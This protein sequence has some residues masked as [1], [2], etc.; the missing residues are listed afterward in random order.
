MD[1]KFNRKFGLNTKNSNTSDPSPNNCCD[2]CFDGR[3][4]ATG[5]SGPPGR[6]GDTGIRGL[7]GATGV[8]GSTGQAGAPGNT[9]SSGVQGPAGPPGETGATGVQGPAGA[10][11]S[12]GEPGA[13]GVQGVTGPSGV[14]GETG[15]EGQTGATGAA[16][17]T[18]ATG[19][20]VTGATGVQGDTGSPGPAGETGA[21]GVG[22]TG[23][24]GASGSQG[25]TGVVGATGAGETGATGVQGET[26]VPGLIGETGATGAGVTGATG[27]DGPTG[28]IGESGATGPTGAGVTGATGVQGSTGATGD[29]GATGPT[30]AGVTGATGVEGPTGS[31]GATGPTGAGVTGA[32][33][34][35]GSTGATGD[36]GATGPTGAG[37]TG[38][39]GI[40]GLTGV[41]GATGP[42]GAGVTGATGPEGPTGATG[43]LG[44]TGASGATGLGVTGAT[45]SSGVQGSTGVAGATGVQGAT[46]VGATGATGTQGATGTAGTFFVNDTAFV[47]P[48]Y[49]NDATA[50]LEDPSHPW[51]TINAAIAAAS[52]VALPANRQWTVFVRNG[53]YPEVILLRPFVDITGEGSRTVLVLGAI[54]DSLMAP[55]PTTNT[56]RNIGITSAL[57]PIFVKTIEGVINMNTVVMF[58]SWSEDPTQQ[59]KS[60]IVVQAGTLNISN[61]NMTTTL[62]S[63]LGQAIPEIHQL[64]E[65]R[66]DA[67]STTPNSFITVR[68]S[69]LTLTENRTVAG[70]ASNALVS[71][72]N[73]GSGPT[74]TGVARTYTYSGS[75]NV[76]TYNN[77]LSPG[78]PA[79]F[80]GTFAWINN[81][82]TQLLT[83]ISAIESESSLTNNIGTAPPSFEPGVFRFALLQL[84]TSGSNSNI[85]SCQVQFASL[86]AL[87]LGSIFT[88]RLVAATSLTAVTSTRW[89]G[90][91]DVPPTEPEY[92]YT[93]ARRVLNN[94]TD[95]YNG[96]QL[97]SNLREFAVNTVVNV[98]STDTTLVFDVDGTVNLPPISQ[99]PNR[100]LI[101]RIMDP[102]GT[103]SITLNSV[104][105]DTIDNTGLATINL[106]GP[107]AVVMQ[108]SLSS[109]RWI[110][111]A[112]YV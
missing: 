41:A 110:F 28:S 52:A 89:R 95:V 25:D 64:I 4:G 107:F 76:F 94:A 85:D 73:I 96:G 26:G 65:H 106:P 58:T 11:G 99:T 19:E 62:T 93:G 56:I 17:A 24:T 91:T 108:A 105:G 29:F 21:T 39:T 75:N 100:I 80:A 81:S 72:V 47:D 48:I 88:S 70:L 40:Q 90:L 22:E 37:V 32:T 103:T 92:I 55:A 46:G 38:A 102:S 15:I 61:C 12:S 30:G 5:A 45:G 9:G 44:N 27:T 84:P 33:G 3:V 69:T 10:T 1:T 2:G 98:Q 59:S 34:P 51:L 8:P 14:Q 74:V 54:N 23:A 78:N 101:V 82:T 6:Q 60:Q 7:N 97:T 109:L 63:I 42:T 77:T 112:N 35:Q 57:R 36:F 53:V 71:M 18:G 79:R 111:I 13:T 50:V 66:F 86:S 104:V 16:G 43:P 67:T 83:T 68:D 31:N 20:G 87:L 49:G